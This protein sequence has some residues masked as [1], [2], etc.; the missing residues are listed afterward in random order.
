LRWV[1]VDAPVYLVT[2]CTRNR[3]PLLACA[4]A[5]TAFADAARRA[6]VADVAV[7]RYV[8][9][10]DHIHAFVRIGCGAR[11]GRTIAA[12]KAA[13]TKVLRAGQAELDVW[14][15]GFFDHLLRSSESYAE[16]WHY[17]RNNPVRAGLVTTPEAWPFQG[18]IVLLMM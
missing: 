5:H 15:D 3:Q 12:L 9:L 10:P 8:I 4:P 16:K 14:Q 7:G 17:V 6:Q 18:E 11:L 13:I 1:F 2:F